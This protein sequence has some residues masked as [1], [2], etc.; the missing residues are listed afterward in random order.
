MSRM[1][2]FSLMGSDAET[3]ASDVLLRLLASDLRVG[4][5]LLMSEDLTGVDPCA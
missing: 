3:S 5:Q 1:T 4:E 2:T